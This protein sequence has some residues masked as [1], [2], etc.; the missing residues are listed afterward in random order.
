MSKSHKNKINFPQWLVSASYEHEM[1]NPKSD[2]RTDSAN[3]SSVMSQGTA[4]L[5]RNCYQTHVLQIGKLRHNAI[6]HSGGTE[7]LEGRAG[8]RLSWTANPDS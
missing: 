6:K 4:I 2:I 3:S 7:Y 1:A 8:N 5:G